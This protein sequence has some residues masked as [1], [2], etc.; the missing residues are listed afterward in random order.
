MHSVGVGI[1]YDSPRLSELD[2]HYRMPQQ[3][4]PA[5]RTRICRVNESRTGEK[6]RVAG[7]F[8]LSSDVQ[9]VGNFDVSKQGFLL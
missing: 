6:L 8:V 1:S 7:K 9:F 4:D 3:T 2:F 5:S